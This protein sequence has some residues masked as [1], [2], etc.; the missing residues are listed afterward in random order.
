MAGAA[1]I[2]EHNT[3]FTLLVTYVAYMVILPFELLLFLGLPGIV[4]PGA[5]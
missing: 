4:P 5:I 2:N 3:A 1:G